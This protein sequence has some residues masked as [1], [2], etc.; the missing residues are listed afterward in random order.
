MT[1]SIFCDLIK[2]VFSIKIMNSVDLS[3]YT[4]EFDLLKEIPAMATNSA[5]DEMESKGELISK[6]WVIGP[7]KSGRNNRCGMYRPKNYMERV[8]YSISNL[9]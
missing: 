4:Y 8:F 9:F 2:T 7:P 5:Y 1:N 6:G 3:R